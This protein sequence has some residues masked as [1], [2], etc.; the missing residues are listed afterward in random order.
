M[1]LLNVDRGTLSEAAS[2]AAI[3]RTLLLRLRMGPLQAVPIFVSIY[4]RADFPNLND[5]EMGD[6]LRVMFLKLSSFSA[7][8]TKFDVP[9]ASEKSSLF[10]EFISFALHH[11]FSV[12]L[13]SFPFLPTRFAFFSGDCV[14]ILKGRAARRIFILF[15]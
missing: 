8:A 4:H 7:F 9:R 12:L 13:L 5:V 3:A 14:A 2:S 11:T 6:I 10:E 1:R 15:F